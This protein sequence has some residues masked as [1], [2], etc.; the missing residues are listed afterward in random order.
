MKLPEYLPGILKRQFY[1]W[2]KKYL[3]LSA[4][5]KM[6]M[7]EHGVEKL[8]VFKKYKF[9]LFSAEPPHIYGNEIEAYDEETKNDCDL[10][11]KFC[12]RSIKIFD[13][14]LKNIYKFNSYIDTEFKLE[15]DF[16]SSCEKQI[17]F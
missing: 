13:F 3:N 6:D 2:Y 14:R 7:F 15:Y 9:V 17:I 10:R 4:S 8:L 5:E 16:C 1:V 12:I 11:V